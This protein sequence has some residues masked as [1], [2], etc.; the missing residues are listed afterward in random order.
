MTFEKARRSN[1]SRFICSICLEA[2]NQ[3]NR[4]PHI[5][6][7]CGH[8]FCF[9]C[10]NAL[11]VQNC[12]ND[13]TPIR[14][15]IP[16]WEIIGQ[17]LNNEDEDESSDVFAEDRYADQVSP[18]EKPRIQPSAPIQTPT[19]NNYPY[20]SDMTMSSATTSQPSHKATQNVVNQSNTSSSTSQS[21]R[22][23]QSRFLI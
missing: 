21:V 15:K 11:K 2:Y 10:I 14:E 7:P 4:R 5:L 19:R 22:E 18:Y 20:P 9:S 8:T 1:S 6:V 13:S 23:L 17:I 12:P 16:N 3:T